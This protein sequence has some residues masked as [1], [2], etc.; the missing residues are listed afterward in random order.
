MRAGSA[1][2]ALK[3]MRYTQIISDLTEI[4]FAAVIHHA[5]PADHLEIGDFCQLGQNVVLHAI[6]KVCVLFLIAQIFKWQNGD[7][8]VYRMSNKF[9]FPND[10]AS[11]CR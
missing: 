9:T 2:A 3:H 5:G 6:G 4:S 10:P 1:D 7:S 8:V 11:S